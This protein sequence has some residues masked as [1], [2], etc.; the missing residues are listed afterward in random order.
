M[1]FR[2]LVVIAVFLALAL[3]V[4]AQIQTGLFVP[5]SPWFSGPL[6]FGVDKP[7]ASGD[8]VVVDTNGDGIPDT[9]FDLPVELVPAPGIEFEYRL[10]PS[11]RTL[12][13]TRFNTESGGLST[14]CGGF[15]NV[16]VWLYALDGPPVLDPFAVVGGSRCVA[17]P[18][19]R[20]P[21]FS[22]ANGPVR[23]MVLI[24]AADGG[25]PGNHQVL[26]ADLAGRQY[27]IDSSTYLDGPGQIAIEFSPSGN[28]AFVTHGF[29][30]V[31]PKYTVVDLC[32]DPLAGA[33]ATTTGNLSG[34]FVQAIVTETNGDF[35]AT[36]YVD[37]LI[38]TSVPLSVD[39]YGTDVGCCFAGGTCDE[40]YDSTT[41]AQLGGQVID[42]GCPAEGCLESCCSAGACALVPYDQCLDD[43]GDP[44]FGF[45]CG[46]YCPEPTEACC[47]PT[48]CYEDTVQSCLD[49]GGTPAGS[50]TTCEVGTC[51]LQNLTLVK[52]GP[53]SVRQG[54]LLTYTID[55][56]NDGDLNATSVVIED[57][58]P[59][60]VEFVSADNGGVLASF[61]RVQWNLGTLSVGAT[62]RLT[63]T[64]RVGCNP[65]DLFNQ[66]YAQTGEGA[67][68]QSN[69]VQTTRLPGVEGPVDVVVA[70]V[71]A[72][73]SPV[74]SGDLITH[75]ITLN[76]PMGRA[77]PGLT[78]ELTPGAGMTFEAVVDAAGG[79]VDTSSVPGAWIWTGDLAASSS[80]SV[81]LTTRVD[82][83][84]SRRTL[85]LNDGPVVVDD[86]CGAAVG[87]GDV[88]E[89]P[90]RR[91]VEVSIRAI[92]LDDP[93]R[94]ERYDGSGIAEQ[95]LQLSRTAQTLDIQIEVSNPWPTTLPNVTVVSLLPFGLTPVGDPPF[96][97]PTDPGASWDSVGSG[98][99]DWTGSL[100]PGET[101]TIT[102]RTTTGVDADAVCEAGLNV[103]GIT[104]TCSIIDRV[105]V[106]HVPDVAS[107]Y[108]AGVS[109]DQGRLWYVRPGVDSVER[110]LLCY[111][112]LAT[113]E[114]AIAPDGSIWVAG[115]PT[116]RV[117][118][119]TL[120]LEPFNFDLRRR[121]GYVPAGVGVDPANGSIVFGGTDF[122]LPFR[123]AF[124][125]FDPVGGTIA[126][127]VTL[128][129][130]GVYPNG[131]TVTTEIIV[132]SGG[133]VWTQY[134]R[135][136]ARVGFDSYE[137]LEN[138]ATFQPIPS[139]ALVFDGNDLFSIVGY[140][141]TLV[142]VD[143]V[144]GMT[145]EE[146]ADLNTVLP[147]SI[148]PPFE[149]NF[150]Q[151]A[152]G[153]SGELYF[154]GADQGIGQIDLA[155]PTGTTLVPFCIDQQ[156]NPD[157]ITPIPPIPHAFD[158]YGGAV[159]CTDADGDGIGGSA[160]CGGTLDCDD[161]DGDIYPGAPELNDG[162][163][164]QCPGDSGHGLVDELPAAATIGVGGEL[165]WPAQTG[166]TE[167]EVVRSTT[168]D[169]STGCVRTTTS[170]SCHTDGD[171]PPAGAT[172]Y[173]L[174]RTLQPNAGSFGADGN[175][176]ERTV[177]CP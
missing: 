48:S 174:V 106:A 98:R 175:G 116:F 109:Y 176:V 29:D 133:T 54:E 3:P 12:Y 28:A 93:V 134:G 58:L 19:A 53:T 114:M 124:S 20:Q 72:A 173:Y 155:G 26:W 13:V 165:C 55:Y 22:D 132:D 47:F 83:C 40:S 36:V 25:G 2:S 21:V 84:T 77:R 42:G 139:D 107:P 119:G 69:S 59:G 34:G 172:F 76:D 57:Y 11:Q 56:V 141:D 146:I 71:G 15:P 128:P 177:S 45:T 67:F 105:D 41:C 43:G 156:N 145:T 101:V 32:A 102:L 111:D 51:P 79:T 136:I 4:S 14:I 158:W 74:A 44:Y 168:P 144:S 135:Q 161:A 103:T 27:T 140:S 171:T 123:F 153:P 39:C 38:E 50:G 126:R 157:C 30:T 86:F 85:R 52:S 63:V 151:M 125:R 104:G 61:G 96:V 142:R 150:D 5:G 16:E 62:G 120:E 97:A 89:L 164:N 75:T 159:P 112:S 82:S 131:P 118:P 148:Y 149:L 68:F 60:G 137:V 1:R 66:V 73:G 170:S 162:K 46:D 115:D 90:V 80:V 127:L 113:G 35:S 108:L 100:A 37:G 154:A 91:A 94:L 17:A 70:S 152:I 88:P 8:P 92:G 167:Y 147:E 129:G 7:V 10:S 166:A 9:A 87:L 138:P 78:F 143:P 130:A 49:S 95:W 65:G 24:G 163:D 160:S 33:G 110:T 99:I 121:L 169:F 117:H 31:Q 6:G 81:V 18:L 23:T 64:V 122:G